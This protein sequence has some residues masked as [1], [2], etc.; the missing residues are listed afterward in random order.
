MHRLSMR[1]VLFAALLVGSALAAEFPQI[2]L[3]GAK[4]LPPE[5]RQQLWQAWEAAGKPMHSQ[6]RRPDGRPQY[7]NRLILAAN[8]YLRLHAQNPVDWYPWG[9]E[10][11]QRARKENKPIFL[12]IGYSTCH[13]CHVMEEESFDNE[14]IARLLNGDFVCIK[15]DREE[16]PDLDAVYI[17]AVQ[18]LT[19]NAGWP[20]TVFLTPEGEPF[21]GG[22]YFPPE[23][24]A[25]RPGMK[26]LLAT[27]SN[28]WK[29]QQQAARDAA[30]SLR[31]ALRAAGPQP[32]SALDEVVLR[33][34]AVHATQLFDATNG[35]FGRAPKFP[36]PHIVQFLLRYYARTGDTAARHMALYTLKKMSQGGIHDL[37]GGGFHRYAT[38]AAWRVPHYEKMLV[39][40]ATI[41]RA[42]IEAA[43]ALPSAEYIGTAVDTLEYALRDLQ[44]PSGA[45]FTA[46]DA[47]SGGQ[48]GTFY[49]WTRDEILDAV[50]AEDGPWVADLFGLTSPDARLPLAVPVAADEFF[51][52]RGM[53][54]KAA[55]AKLDKIR[56]ALLA[57]RARRPRPARDEKILASWNGL[58]IAAL[59]EAGGRWNKAEYLAAAERAANWILSNMRPSGRLR[60]SWYR[61]QLGNHAYLEDYAYLSL[62]L[63][64]LFKATGESRWLKEADGMLAA[65]LERFWDK[66]H[67]TLRYTSTDHEALFAGPWPLEDAAMP[68]AHS[69]AAEVLLRCGHLLHN[70]VYQ[71]SGYNILRA[72]GA[73]IAKA[74]TA[75]AYA[76][77]ALDFAL[78]PRQEIVVVG[79]RQQPETAALWKIAQQTYLPRAVTVLH[80]PRDEGLR[81]LLPFLARQ[82]MQHRK[83]T[84]YVCENFT[85]KLPVSEPAKLVEQLAA[86]QGGLAKSTP[87]TSPQWSLP[88][89]SSR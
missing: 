78:G 27:V 1:F 35:G 85:C 42:Y 72:N 20:L 36:Q 26:R 51:Q 4:P 49:L 22:T 23:D 18:R 76:V 25:G 45:F 58:M 63:F 52:Q 50:G 5:L 39:D 67:N 24:V 81:T 31:D 65:M 12:S 70:K 6:H 46:E 14:E 21:Y 86:L 17:A 7:L 37:L 80:D 32:G 71:E 10:A 16:R 74:P 73:D 30:A 83:P 48:E 82:P 3:P 15:V 43:L 64:E 41:A 68:A 34:A 29:N 40:Q 19:G 61:G 84:A 66:Q 53:D 2:Q 11:L 89:L 69:V 56:N 57:A 87:A 75:Y 54:K 28:S 88:T 9:E 77:M 60:H 62:G 44:A 59:A 38:D 79:P 47:Q 13:W 55:A 33:R 8:P